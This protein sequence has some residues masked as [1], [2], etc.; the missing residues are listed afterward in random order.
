[1]ASRKATPS[2]ARARKGAAKTPV[3]S[4]D[5]KMAMLSAVMGRQQL[6]SRVAGLQYAGNRDVYKVA[7]YVPQGEVKFAHYWGLYTRG[8]IAGRIVDMPAQTTWRTPPEITEDTAEDSQRDDRGDTEFTRKFRQL[9]KQVKLWRYLTRCDRLAGVGQYAVLMLG[10]KVANVQELQQ[11]LTRLPNA[12]DLLYL[13]VYREDNAKI[14]VWENDAASPRFGMPKMYE[15]QVTTDQQRTGGTTV[16]MGTNKLLVHHTRVLHV[17]ENLLE[18]EVY[19]RPRLERCLN[20]LFDLDKVAASTGEA[21]WQA[22]VR[23]LQAKIDPEFD[24]T[25]AQMAS[26][27]E[28]LSEIVHDLRRQFYG[29]G[30]ELKWLENETPNV[31]EVADFYF[32]L[33]AGAAGIPKRILFGSE[34]GELASSTDQQTYYGMINERQ[35]QFAEPML[36]RAF[37]DRMIA[38]GTLPLPKDGE[39]QVV[40]P[41]LFEESDLTKA[42]TSLARAQAASALTPIGGNPRELVTV[43]SESNVFIAERTEVDPPAPPE[44]PNDPDEEDDPD[45]PPEPGA[46]GAATPPAQEDE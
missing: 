42:Q 13:S 44:P 14:T 32:S 46:G 25:E 41:T 2:S 24:I 3:L 23:I 40:W 34:M 29:Q 31:H 12:K 4:T 37:V 22:V 17:A 21:Y 28:K 20:R 35:E 18:D 43:D 7:G 8:D 9:S 16:S 45:A 38:L 15:L 10:T 30:V 33:I 1:M 6:A 36:M 27:D 11:P 19:G 5:Q 26:M 39:Y